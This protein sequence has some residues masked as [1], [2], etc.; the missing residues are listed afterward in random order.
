MSFYDFVSRSIRIGLLENLYRVYVSVAVDWLRPTKWE[1]V[2]QSIGATHNP[3][4]PIDE[5]ISTSTSIQSSLWFF[6]CFWGQMR[7]LTFFSSKNS[8]RVAKRRTKPLVLVILFGIR[9][10]S[11]H[12]TM[13][14]PSLT[15]IER[16]H[17]EMKTRKMNSPE[18]HYLA[19]FEFA[20]SETFQ[21][22]TKTHSPV[23]H[24]HCV[25]RA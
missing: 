9:E 6:E 10:E 1:N 13:S 21:N 5:H 7:S 4:G 20:N 24:L 25:Q 8:L 16:D 2:R 22:S 14:P 12:S 17:K 23:H 3:S 18:A 19:L 11:G 15:G